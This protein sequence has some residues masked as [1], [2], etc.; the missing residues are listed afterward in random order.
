[1]RLERDVL[2][3]P[4]T[5]L[6]LGGKASHVAVVEREEDVPEALRAGRRE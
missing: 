1:M 4:L 6:R 2:L 5:T 3:A